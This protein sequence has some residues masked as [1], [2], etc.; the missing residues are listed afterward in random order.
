[1][2][3][4]SA[5]SLSASVYLT[6]ALP[7]FATHGGG[8]NFEGTLCPSNPNDLDEVS[9]V[10]NFFRLC[11][12]SL[13]NAVLSNLLNIVFI[14]AVIIALAFL[15]YG[16]IRWITS[17]G[18]KTKVEAARNTL[19]AALIGLV[20]VFLSYFIIQIIFSIFG[21]DFAGGSFFGTL[22]IF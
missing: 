15:I 20:L 21:I 3:K 13:T 16:G 10:M 17:G 6:S 11:E 4:L 14:I 7:A 1:M 22:S 9:G 8:H 18:D 12:L 2:K 19:V 5:I